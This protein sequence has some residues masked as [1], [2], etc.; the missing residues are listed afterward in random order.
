MEKCPTIA[1]WYKNKSHKCKGGTEEIKEFERV[2]SVSAL[3]HKDSD[4]M[5]ADS[6]T[7]LHHVSD[8]RFLSEVKK[9]DK[10][11]VVNTANG[12]KVKVEKAG[13]A[14]VRSDEL[15]SNMVLSDVKYTPEFKVNLFSV[16]KWIDGGKENCRE[17]VF[18]KYGVVGRENGERIFSGIRRDN[19]YVLKLNM[20]SDRKDEFIE[21]EKA[22]MVTKEEA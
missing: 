16:A 7:T 18:S 19:L 8:G 21:D 1:I 20:L 11:I 9:M 5:V 14:I 13:K 4:C 15:K 2:L 17:I 10:N 6:G 12:G 3:S 22:Y